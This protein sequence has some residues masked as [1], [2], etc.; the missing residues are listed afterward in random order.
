M[1]KAKSPNLF[2]SQAAKEKLSKLQ[3]GLPDEQKTMIQTELKTIEK[4][5]M[6]MTK[7]A[8]KS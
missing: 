2:V 7:L 8:M 1:V 3:H 5:S 6:R 4:R